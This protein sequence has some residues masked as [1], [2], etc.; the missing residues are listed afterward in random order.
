MILLTVK[1]YQTKEGKVPVEGEFDRAWFR[2]F[3][4]ETNQTLDYSMIKNVEIEGGAYEEM[5]PNE[6]EEKPPNF[7]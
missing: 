3:N 7:N 4:E 5:I 1:A 2:L 6:D